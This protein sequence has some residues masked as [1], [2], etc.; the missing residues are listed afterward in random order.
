[1]GM[2]NTSVIKKAAEDRRTVNAVERLVLKCGVRADLNG[3]TYLS[4]AAAVFSAHPDSKLKDICD[5]VGSIHGVKPKTVMREI[6]YAVAQAFDISETLSELVGARI[7]PSHI[8]GRLVI[9][10]I[11]KLCGKPSTTDDK[12]HEPRDGNSD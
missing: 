9:A 2:N 8:H 7:P 11:G 1:M 3:Y 10:Y 4:E 12:T 5:A 6:N